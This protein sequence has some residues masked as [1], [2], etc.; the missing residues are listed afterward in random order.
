M[1]TLPQWDEPLN[2]QM[3][4]YCDGLGNFVRGHNDWHF[5]SGRYF[6][7]KGPGVKEK[8]WVDLLPKKCKKGTGEVGCVFVDSSPL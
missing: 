2:S 5:E 1:T 4:E 3:K 8:G 7:D 6:G